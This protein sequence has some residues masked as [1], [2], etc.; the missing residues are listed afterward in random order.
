MSIE[1][2]PRP[3]FLAAVAGLPLADLMKPEEE[4]EGG[5]VGQPDRRV[6]GGLDR[7]RKRPAERSR[8]RRTGIVGRHGR[9]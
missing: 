6:I 1:Q 3:W 2:L 8:R 7:R 5:P 9:T 4:E